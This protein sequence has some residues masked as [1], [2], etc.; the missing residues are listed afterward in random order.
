MHVTSYLDNCGELER[1]WLLKGSHVELEVVVVGEEEVEVVLGWCYELISMQQQHNDHVVE[2]SE[3]G[4]IK[5]HLKSYNMFGLLLYTSPTDILA[6]LD[7]LD[8][9]FLG[10]VIGDDKLNVPGLGNGIKV[11]CLEAIL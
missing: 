2:V 10:D 1:R 8:R 9:N 4:N 6:T 5:P 11:D 7:G 3:V